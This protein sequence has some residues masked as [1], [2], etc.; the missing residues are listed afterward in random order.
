MFGKN[1]FVRT[2]DQ[3]LYNILSH[4]ENKILET[5][6]VLMTYY[7][8]VFNNNFNHEQ[9]DL[10]QDNLMCNINNVNHDNFIN[11]FIKSNLECLL[12]Q[13]TDLTSEK[14]YYITKFER[15]MESIF[16]SKDDQPFGNHSYYA[17]M[18]FN[19]LTS[20]VKLERVR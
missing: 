17:F 11:K 12:A 1:A 18:V 14:E 9:D 20:M 13:D 4:L 5:H 15:T 19:I 3:K 10:V 2:D 16:D 6:F 8:K 7:S